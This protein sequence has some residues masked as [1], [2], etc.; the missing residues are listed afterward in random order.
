[1][2]FKQQWNLHAW[3][4]LFISM[5]S[6]CWDEWAMDR[7]F[8][9]LIWRVQGQTRRGFVY[10]VSALQIQ[11]SFN[12]QYFVGKIRT[13]PPHWSWSAN[14]KCLSRVDIRLSNGWSTAGFE[15]D[16]REDMAERLDI[17]SLPDQI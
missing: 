7:I 12:F 15:L 17:R 14:N 9:S 16:S 10:T 4:A 1:M 3:A 13:I 2:E 6:T 5:V 8:L 11:G